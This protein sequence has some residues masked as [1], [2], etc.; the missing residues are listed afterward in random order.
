VGCAIWP[1]LREAASGG[2]LA[3]ADI[4]VSIVV[5]LEITPSGADTWRLEVKILIFTAVG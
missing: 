1:I 4:L 3:L 2:P 5:L